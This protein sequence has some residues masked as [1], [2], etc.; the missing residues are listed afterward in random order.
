MNGRSLLAELGRRNV[1][2]AAVLYGGGTWAVAQGI[3]QLGPAFGA[4]EWITRWF[5]V[6]AVIGF[7]LWII[8]AWFYEFTP[9]GL[10]RESE[11]A[12][13]DSIAHQTGRKLDFWII[14]VLAGAVVL[15]LTNTFVWHKGAGLG[16]DAGIAPIPAKSI[17]VLPLA[18]ESGDK[19]EQY[20]S[21]GLSEDL[22]TALSQFAGLKVISRNSAFQFRDSKESSKVIG[23]KLGVAHLLEGSVR[24]AGTTVRISATLV[25]AIDGSTLWSEH[26]DRLYT[27]LFKLQDDITH[28]VAAEL[29]AKLLSGARAVL[30]SDRPPSGSLVAYDTYLQAESY[31]ASNSE[32]G[33]RK[34]IDYFNE[35]V[36]IDPRYARAYAG[37][38]HAW[39]SHAAQ[40][41]SGTAMKQ[42]YARAREAANFAL[43]LDPDLASAHVA[44]AYLLQ[45]A[46]FDWSGADA[47]FRRA[48]QLAPE[49]GSAKF[50]RGVL[51]ATMGKLEPAV[52]LTRQALASDPLHAIWYSW[53][54]QYFSSLGRLD[55]AE[56]AIG[57]AIALQPG[58]VG[59]Y[60]TLAI[61]KVQRGDA[62][63]ALRVAQQESP[64]MWRDTALAL[65]RQIGGDSAAGSAALRNLIDKQGDNAAYQIAEVYALR[66]EP[67]RMFEWLDRAWALRDPGISSLLYD[68]FLL[69]YKE[70]SRFAAF[71]KKAGLPAPDEITAKRQA[72]TVSSSATAVV[73]R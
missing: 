26:Y 55:E 67:E 4:P 71:R 44:R 17:A 35:A 25:N 51:L 61:I 43:A 3:A 32:S 38:S 30:Q 72:P 33:D 37:L 13:E 73:R 21:D 56:Q 41:L 54:A 9:Q 63:A 52:R 27:D 42:A 66:K 53:L 19:S 8:F 10:K 11:I 36:R 34:A 20:F 29:K 12:P 28:A 70:D 68:P 1:L 23:E 16:S 59:Q 65:A 14:G 31:D 40:F 62:H 50:M 39:T 58:A 49:D 45:S 22:I 6:A 60:E 2:R 47:E 69:R 64:G 5:V 15:L 18:N 57:R 24:R 48:L 46:D 7:P